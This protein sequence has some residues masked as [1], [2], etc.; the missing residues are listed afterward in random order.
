[1]HSAMG[2]ALMQ[3][4]GSMQVVFDGD[5]PAKAIYG[6]FAN[7]GGMLAALLAEQ[8][9]GARIA[10]FEGQAGLYGLF[11]GG[12]YEQSVLEEGLGSDWFLLQARFKPWP[13]S[14]NVHP[15]IEAATTIA[16]QG[17][18][19]NDIASIVARAGPYLRPWCEPI[20][21]RRRPPNPASAANSIVYGIAKALVNGHVGLRDFTDEGLVQKDALRLAEH[22]TC[23]I[24]EAYVGKGTVEVRTHDGRVFAETVTHPLGHPSRPLSQDQL[25]AKFRDCAAH[26][27]VLFPAAQLDMLIDELGALETIGDARRIGDLA[28]GPLA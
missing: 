18:K 21:E 10:A 17:V 8:G 25:V 15:Y 7:L 20:E 2:T 12:V 14:G 6:G 22:A 4:G 19:P 13:T 16:Q 27:A 28:R 11:Y 9:L 24:D 5:P 1:M 3:A 23:E 26:A